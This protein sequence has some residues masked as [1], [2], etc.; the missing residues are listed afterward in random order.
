MNFLTLLFQA[1]EAIC[2]FYYKHRCWAKVQS[3]SIWSLTQVF[4]EVHLAASF[5]PTAILLMVTQRRYTINIEL[6]IDNIWNLIYGPISWFLL[7]FLML[8]KNKSDVLEKD[9]CIYRTS[10]TLSREIIW[11]LGFKSYPCPT[12]HIDSSYIHCVLDKTSDVRFYLSIKSLG[13]YL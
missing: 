8:L 13:I 9:I 6:S 12:N 5:T 2:E 11:E 1:R 7:Y 4:S 10:C 3:C